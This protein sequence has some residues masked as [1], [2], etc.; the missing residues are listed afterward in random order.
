M[1]VSNPLEIIYP[2][3]FNRRHVLGD[4]QPYVCTSHDC[5]QAEMTYSTSKAY[6]NH[7]RAK[8]RVSQKGESFKRLV[9]PVDCLFCGERLE[10]SKKDATHLHVRRHM[11]EIAFTVVTK[12]YEDWE[13]YSN[14]SA[15]SDVP[16]GWCGYPG[17]G[18]YFAHQDEMKNHQMEVHELVV[19]VGFSRNYRFKCKAIHGTDGKPCDFEFGSLDTFSFHKRLKA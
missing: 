8:H 17:C 2:A 16:S 7:L 15:S 3:H 13:F 9:R 19:L 5:D 11:E 12:P 4:L 18:E 10:L 14:S 1:A 6:V